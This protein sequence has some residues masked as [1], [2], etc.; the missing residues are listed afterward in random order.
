[1]ILIFRCFSDPSDHIATS[2]LLL[3]LCLVHT[4][5]VQYIYCVQSLYCQGGSGGKVSF[6]LRSGKVSEA[7][8][9]QGENSSFFL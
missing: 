5:L 1:M 2:P 7:C 8:N 3:I 9:G 6:S 4:L